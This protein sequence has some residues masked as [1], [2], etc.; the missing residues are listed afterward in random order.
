[1]TPETKQKISNSNKGKVRTQSF[2]DNLSKVASANGL[3]GHTSKKRIVFVKKNGE[4]V[5]LQ[6]SYETRL[7]TLLEENNI[8]WSRPAPLNW[9]DQHGKSHRYYPDFEINGKFFDTK[10]DYLIQKDADKINRVVTQNNVCVFVL[11]DTDIHIEKI[12]SLL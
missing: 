4:T 1:M 6:S 3:G 5:F 7:A 9:I 11:R 12:H 10:N 2:K 8:E